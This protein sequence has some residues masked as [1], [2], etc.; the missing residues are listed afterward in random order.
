MIYLAIMPEDCEYLRNQ[1]RRR[2]QKAAEE[3]QRVYA[4][5]EVDAFYLQVIDAEIQTNTRILDMCHAAL[6]AK[7]PAETQKNTIT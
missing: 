6:I 2:I 7:A 5:G 1:A 3:V 4:A